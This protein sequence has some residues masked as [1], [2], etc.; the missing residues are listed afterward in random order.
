MTVKDSAHVGDMSRPASQPLATTIAK[1]AQTHAREMTRHS[2]K[3]AAAAQM[4]RELAHINPHLG[5]ELT[6]EAFLGRITRSIAKRLGRSSQV[7]ATG[8]KELAEGGARALGPKTMIQPSISKTMHVPAPSPGLS[9]TVNPL[10]QTGAAP[11]SAGPS[12]R[13]GNKV[14]PAPTSKAV[15][16]Y[17]PDPAKASM[18]M[19]VTR[20]AGAKPLSA[21]PANLPKRTGA[22]FKTVGDDLASTG[23]AVGPK[24]H[25]GAPVGKGAKPQAER[26]KDI[27]TT[28]KA[29][30]LAM[31][32]K[33]FDKA[34]AEAQ[35]V[36]GS[37]G[38]GSYAVVPKKTGPAP[39][40]DVLAGR[41]PAPGTAPISASAPAGGRAS[42]P[43][44]GAPSGALPAPNVP[45]ARAQQQS[46]A[47]ERLTQ[48][49]INP[50]QA[51]RLAEAEHRITLRGAEK[52][53]TPG[54]VTPTR[55]KPEF[56]GY[57]ASRQG[58]IPLFQA[59]MASIKELMEKYGTEERIGNIVKIGSILE[60]AEKAGKRKAAKVSAHFEKSGIGNVLGGIGKAVSS[61]GKGV[62][63]AGGNPGKAALI[64]GAGVTGVAG[65][66]AT[67]YGLHKGHQRHR[68]RQ[69][70]AWRTGM[71]TPQ[72][73]YRRQQM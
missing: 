69:H 36:Y 28:E 45:M 68:T 39:L 42:V 38:I 22:E 55:I 64:G 60:S 66:A 40:K 37:R 26:I 61:V 67:G 27:K 25:K 15:P 62:A 23:A 52:S 56:Q 41:A 65:L 54:S 57:G 10:G 18:G 71:G 1:L 16:A 19:D 21:A 34:R 47:V 9:K 13:I 32:Q 2:M 49:G 43:S 12:V 8:T 30:Q 29:E 59:K 50:Q 35:D 63:W 51:K 14:M 31:R 48:A 7:A 58:S 17:K 4:G 20:G 3:V 46:A 44:L 5:D 72:P 73:Y 24:L 6:K 11:V 53:V 33:S 70:T